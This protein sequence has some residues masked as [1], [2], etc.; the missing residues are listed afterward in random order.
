VRKLNLLC[1]FVLLCGWLASPALAD[2]Y[3]LTSGQS[4]TGDPVSMN[5]QGTLFS[6]PDGTY[7][8][9]VSWGKFSQADLKKIGAANPKAQ[10]FV[11][12]FLEPD[13]NQQKAEQAAIEVK[14]D[15]P[16]LDRPAAQPFLKS[17]ASTGIGL[18][19]LFFIYAA[20][21]YAGYEI[22]IFRARSPG[23]V[24]GVSAVAPLLGPIIFLCLPTQVESREDIVQEPARE[25][26]AY[27]AG[28]VPPEGEVAE[29]SFVDDT[30]QLPATETFARGQYTFN[31]RFFE[32]KFAGFFTVVRRED[33]RDMVLIFR[34]NRGT[35]E[36]QRITRV[37]M[38]DLHI[39]VA[40]GHASEE[41]MIPF[42][43]IQEVT[44][45]HK[46]A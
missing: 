35:Y 24:C 2:T 11:E 18:L 33:I 28:E 3:Q 25:K 30:P 36:A 13:L 8:D 17:L 31:R 23:L 21:I 38:N 46:D 6:L 34:A 42:I 22:S 43:E 19:A 14:T 20:N 27:Y 41:V 16:R 12:P 4:I 40:K 5:E 39:Q 26:E 44:L 7:S 15:Y 1:I 45:K 29:S 32:T 9:R 37:A 10:Q